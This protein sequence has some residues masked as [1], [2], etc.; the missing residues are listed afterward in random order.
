ML[1]FLLDHLLEVV[2]TAVLE[3]MKS[4]IIE[5]YWLAYYAKTP[6]MR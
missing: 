3:A 4:D 2:M 1:F 5:D 6:Y